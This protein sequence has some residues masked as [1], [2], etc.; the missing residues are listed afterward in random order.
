MVDIKEIK[1]IDEFKDF[2][3]YKSENLHVIK[4]GSEY[5]GPCKLLDSRLKNLEMEKIGDSLFCKVD[6]SEDGLED[7]GSDYGIMAIP[8]MVYIKNGEMMK[9]TNGLVTLDDIYNSIKEL[10]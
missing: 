7:I 6:L 8:S 10:S 3:N 4:F 2:L 9:K 1:S 5:C